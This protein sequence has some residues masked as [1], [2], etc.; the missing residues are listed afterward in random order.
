MIA[1]PDR[2]ILAID[3]G[4]THVK[5][6][7]SAHAEK[8]KFSSGTDL[9]AAEMVSQTLDLTRDWTY[10]VVS[11]G[12]PGPVIH[13]RPLD[14]PHNLGKG[15]VGFNF[16]KAFERRSGSSTTQPCRRSAATKAGACCFWGWGPGLGP[17]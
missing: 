9:T 7:H 14:E 1:K 3:V 6:L 13:N 17:P 4:G 11:I 16:A 10:D 12:Y 5:V 8:R 15:W 2:R